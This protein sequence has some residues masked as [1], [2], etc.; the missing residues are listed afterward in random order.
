MN[1]ILDVNKQQQI[2]SNDESGKELK[3]I[4]Y[5]SMTIDEIFDYLTESFESKLN[6][7][8]RDDTKELLNLYL[9]QGEKILK[10]KRNVTVHERLH[11]KFDL[12]TKLD[13]VIKSKLD[14]IDIKT[15]E[16]ENSWKSKLANPN[17]GQS[18]NKMYNASIEMV[19]D[20]KQRYN[21]IKS[22]N[23]LLE[24]KDVTLNPDTHLTKRSN[25]K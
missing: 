5:E 9:K 3:N 8:N 25:M 7:C 16:E 12:R 20:R 13:E 19:N 10:F 11:K 1:N 14:C 15:N 21:L 17:T 18:L 22:H 23:E 2:D 6:I 4:D 24:M